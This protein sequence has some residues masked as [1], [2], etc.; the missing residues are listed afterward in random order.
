MCGSR[1]LSSVEAYLF[2]LDPV[3]AKSK[4]LCGLAPGTGCARLLGLPQAD[5]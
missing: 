2:T 3:H 5:G 1:T 4:M